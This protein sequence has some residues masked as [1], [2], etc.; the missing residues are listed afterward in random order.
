MI[1]LRCVNGHYE[2]GKEKKVHPVVI[3]PVE[4]A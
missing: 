2:F 3:V 1:G 4:E